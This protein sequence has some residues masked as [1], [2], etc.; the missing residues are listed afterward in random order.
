MSSILRLCLNTKNLG[1][2]TEGNCHPKPYV[3]SGSLRLVDLH[4]VVHKYLDTRKGQSRDL[5]TTVFP[6]HV[7]SKSRLVGTPAMWFNE[8]PR[9]RMTPSFGSCAIC[10]ELSSPFC[11]RMNVSS[12][13]LLIPLACRSCCCFES[14]DLPHLWAGEHTVEESS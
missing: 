3:A 8:H 12:T 11:W 13:K 6:V 5:V 9:F 1:I 2:R 7:R 14:K 4:A 10:M